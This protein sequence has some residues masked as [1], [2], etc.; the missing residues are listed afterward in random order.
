MPAQLIK[1]RKT[2]FTIVLPYLIR[3]NLTP[4]LD[5]NIPSELF[6]PPVNIAKRTFNT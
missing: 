2:L 1:L 3:T 5:S 4:A 6:L